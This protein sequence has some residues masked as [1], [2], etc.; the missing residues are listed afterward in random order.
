M[1]FNYGIKSLTEDLMVRKIKVRR[2]KPKFTTEEEFNQFYMTHCFSCRKPLPENKIRA[3]IQIK[4][5]NP[6]IRFM[7]HC[8]TCLSKKKK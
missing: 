2:P 5:D 8:D 7:I 4:K 3:H 1:S 6:E